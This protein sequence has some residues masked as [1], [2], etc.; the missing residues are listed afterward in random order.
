[1]ATG[2]PRPHDGRVTE[3]RG[4]FCP[5]RPYEATTDAHA[6]EVLRSVHTIAVIGAH[7][8][9]ARAAHYVPAYMASQGYRILPVNPDFEGRALFGEPAVAR[10]GDLDEPV[11]MVNV[12]RRSDAVIDHVDEVLAMR[13]LPR[14]VWLQSGI[15]NDEAAERLAESGHRRDP[16]SLRPRRSPAPGRALDAGPQG[17]GPRGRW[18]Q[19]CWASGAT[20]CR[21]STRGALER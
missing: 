11:D 3:P 14:V 4:D 2:L 5:V 13:P 1:M 7:A 9:A 12:F 6:A 20:S 18:M 21:C 10:L 15:R 17:R 8:Q 19:S 16:G